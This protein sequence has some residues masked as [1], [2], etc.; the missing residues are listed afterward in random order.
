MATKTIKK[1]AASI[2]P[3]NEEEMKAMVRATVDAQLRLEG[4]ISQRDAAQL[5][6]A[7]P[8]ATD[9][10]DLENLMAR[11]VE[12]LEAWSALNET[13]FGKAKS[14]AVE[15]HRLGWK[16]GNWKTKLKSKGTW[17]AVVAKL[18]GWINAARPANLPKDK[19]QREEAKARADYARTWL[20]SKLEVAANKDAMIASRDDEAAAPLLKEIG[21]EIIQDEEF[22]LAPN[23]EGQAE[24]L[25]TAA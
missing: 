19:E 23:R 15:M 24:P 17:E 16:L 13:V 14:I 11:N 5:A 20:R 7:K 4:L 22:F 18:R 10:S 2:V 1:Q 8:F 25:L 21:V 3:R 9:I 12:A 6:A